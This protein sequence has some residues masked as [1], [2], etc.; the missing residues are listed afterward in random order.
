MDFDEF[1]FSRINYVV[2]TIDP[3]DELRRWRLLVL[4]RG[5]RIL[6]LWGT[7]SLSI[8][9]CWN[10]NQQETAT[11]T[12][13]VLLTTAVLGASNVIVRP[14]KSIPV[15]CKDSSTRA[16]TLRCHYHRRRRRRDHHHRCHRA[17]SHHGLV[18]PEH[19][20]ERCALRVSRGNAAHRDKE[21]RCYAW[22]WRQHFS[23]HKPSQKHAHVSMRW[24]CVR[25]RQTRLHTYEWTFLAASYRHWIL[26]CCHLMLLCHVTT[27]PT[28]T[29]G[30]LL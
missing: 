18:K 29:L 6:S 20:A 11:I 26:N 10:W 13:G 9:E 22:P 7:A 14:P 12:S 27:P 4:V 19:L 30:F 3:T 5:P 17:Q 8:T 23:P 24:K 28:P 1:L 25:P 16:G 2:T 15:R 21:A